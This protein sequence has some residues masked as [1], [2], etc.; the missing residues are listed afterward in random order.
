MMKVTGLFTKIL[1]DEHFIEG[2]GR[3]EVW[4]RVVCNIEAGDKKWTGLE[5]RIAHPKDT[6]FQTAPLTIKPMSDYDGPMNWDA[7]TDL[8]EDFYRKTVTRIFGGVV[9]GTNIKMT[10]NTVQCNLPFE[11]EA[12]DAARVGW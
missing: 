10:N 12:D 2:Q 9:M 1:Q 5:I 4:V 8:I 3:G 6:D 7:F 11:F